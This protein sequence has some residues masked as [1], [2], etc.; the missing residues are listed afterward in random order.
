MAYRLHNQCSF[1]A[2]RATLPYVT[3]SFNYLP[4]VLLFLPPF[5][6]LPMPG[7]EA[8]SHVLAVLILDECHFVRMRLAHFKPC[9]KFNHCEVCLAT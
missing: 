6:R 7:L 2:L 5:V 3:R 9:S 4:L 1:P 8:S